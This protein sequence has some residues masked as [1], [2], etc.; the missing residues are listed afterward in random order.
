MTEHTTTDELGPTLYVARYDRG[1]GQ[2]PVAIAWGHTQAEAI[3]RGA[4]RAVHLGWE[5]GLTGE[6]G[7]LFTVL[8]RS[9]LSPSERADIKRG[10]D[11]VVDAALT[12]PT[13]PVA[14]DRS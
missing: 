6:D 8:P 11:E 12:I 2:G 5:D 13:E 7:R 3:E 9:G 1:D 4:S 14:G 10:I